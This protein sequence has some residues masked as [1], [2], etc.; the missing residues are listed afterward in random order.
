VIS[1]VVEVDPSALAIG[2]RVRAVFE[3]VTDEISLPKFR[4]EA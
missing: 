4:L 3:A 1:N 2:R